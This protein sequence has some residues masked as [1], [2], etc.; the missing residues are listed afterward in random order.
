MRNFSSSLETQLMLLL[1]AGFLYRH[2]RR[3]RRC[4][5]SVVAHIFVRD[6]T[7]GIVD[8][9]LHNRSSCSFSARADRIPFQV[10]ATV[11]LNMVNAP[12]APFNGQG[13]CPAG[14]QTSIAEEAVVASARIDQHKVAGVGF[15]LQAETE[16][17]HREATR[18]LISTTIHSR[19]TD[20]GGPY[21]EGRA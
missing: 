3:W 6:L 11:P 2:C 15:V 9:D 20:C 18:R 5:A 19:A 8:A 14:D 13:T 10:H 12:L 17:R 21:R 4:R 16:H 7:L 1:L